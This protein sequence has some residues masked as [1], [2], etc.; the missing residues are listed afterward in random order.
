MSL[1][2][3]DDASV[4]RFP[5]QPLRHLDA[6]WIQVAGTECNLSCAHC[7][8]PSGPGID[9]HALMSRAQ[10]RERVSEAL[11]FG[12]REL[13]LT[14]G[15]PFV[16]PELFEI[17]GDSLAHLP[18]TVLTNGTLFTSAR[19]A[20]LRHL[21][22]ESRYALELRMSLDGASA[23]AHD[24]V[25]GAGTFERTISGLI[26][27]EAHDLCPIVTV[28]QWDESEPLEFRDQWVSMLRAR[29]LRRPRL[30][31][32]P[33]F[34]LGRESERS[35]GYAREE[36]LAGLTDDAFDPE[37][38]QCGSSRAITSQGVFVCPLLVDEPRAR[39]GATLAEARTPFELR[40]GA[41]FTCYRT[42]MTCG[43]G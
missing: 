26:R 34:R 29:G 36:S 4:A 23:D 11:A 21:S 28:T 35:G 16:N 31:V 14:G 32:L 27:C 13:Y 30:K 24:R 15:E 43:N 39:L 19:L 20:A 5:L 7:F 25:R 40:H 1:V 17:L 38:L 10:V 6:L 18:C 33:L 3:I 22:D 42:G 2:Q 9:R 12:V 37:R 8:V 41:C